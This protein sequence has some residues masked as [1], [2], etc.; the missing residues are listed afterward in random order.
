M[1][2][3]DVV[4]TMGSVDEEEEDGNRKDYQMIVICYK[5]SVIYR[6]S[7]GGRGA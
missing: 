3:L 2:R 6:G 5:L 1:R 4:E 7:V